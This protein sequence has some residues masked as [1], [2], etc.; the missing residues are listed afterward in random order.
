MWC[1]TVPVPKVAPIIVAALLIGNDLDA[2]TLFGQVL[3]GLIDH[4]MQVISYA[5]DGTEVEC[6]VQ[7]LLIEEAESIEHV[8]KKPQSG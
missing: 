2:S 4:G 5:C 3:D 1:L 6:S 8:I 7:C